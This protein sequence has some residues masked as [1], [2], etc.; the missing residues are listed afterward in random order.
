[1][2]ETLAVVVAGLIVGQRGV[3]RTARDLIGVVRGVTNVTL[4]V[5]E[6]VV[7][8]LE[9]LAKAAVDQAAT[10]T[11]RAKAKAEL[12]RLIRDNPEVVAALAE[13]A[14]LRDCRCN[15]CGKPSIAIPGDPCFM[16][17]PG[18]YQPIEPAGK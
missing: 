8:R 11:D 13:A 10:A 17:C 4:G 7:E 18:T 6:G 9:R 1:M 14:K 15:V 2:L 3:A 12:A 16:G 5:A